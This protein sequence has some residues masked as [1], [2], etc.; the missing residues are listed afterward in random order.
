MLLNNRV[1]TKANAIINIPTFTKPIEQ[2]IRV[3]IEVTR[4]TV[5]INT[6]L[7]NS[8]MRKILLRSFG[9]NNERD[10]SLRLQKK[11]KSVDKR[12]INTTRLAFNNAVMKN[13]ISQVLIL[14][15]IITPMKETNA[16]SIAK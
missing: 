1:V 4:A 16:Q 11:S 12:N 5:K 3:P 7:Q 9:V 6:R 8:F 2:V 15:V 10:K 14:E 13:P